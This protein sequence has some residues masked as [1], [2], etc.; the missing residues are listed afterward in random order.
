M[1]LILSALLL[2]AGV[3]ALAALPWTD[4]D[5]AQVHRT[6]CRLTVPFTRAKQAHQEAVPPDRQS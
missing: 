5:I 4:A 2:F 3:L 6:A 1:D